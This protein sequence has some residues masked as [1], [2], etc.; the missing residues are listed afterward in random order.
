MNNKLA[1]FRR[2]DGYSLEYRNVQCTSLHDK[3]VI[4]CHPASGTT[5]HPSYITSHDKYRWWAVAKK[6]WTDSHEQRVLGRPRS[7]LSKLW[8]NEKTSPARNKLSSGKTSGAESERSVVTHWYRMWHRI[9][10]HYATRTDRH[11]DLPL[12]WHLPWNDVH[13]RYKLEKRQPRSH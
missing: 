13:H 7:I 3:K 1:R 4:T 10:C 8:Y 6:C 9:D 11:Q 2:M 5:R 12:L